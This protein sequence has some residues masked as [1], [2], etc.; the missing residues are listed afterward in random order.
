MQIIDSESGG[1]ESDKAKHQKKH[2]ADDDLKATPA[3]TPAEG[4]QANQGG[5]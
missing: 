5:A 1:T 2:L 4:K 3:I